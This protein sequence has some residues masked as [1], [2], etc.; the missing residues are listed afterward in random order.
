MWVFGTCNLLP[1]IRITEKG[2][3][4]DRLPKLS[5]DSVPTWSETFKLQDPRRATGNGQG[6]EHERGHMVAVVKLT[7]Q[8]FWSRH[9][10]ERRDE[11]TEC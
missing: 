5:L 9:G 11:G 7:V 1:C 8:F 10:H 6:Q 2:R 4:C 3:F